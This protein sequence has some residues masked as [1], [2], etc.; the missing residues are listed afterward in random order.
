MGPADLENTLA[1][2]GLATYARFI[3]LSETGIGLLLLTRRF[4]TLGALFLA[5]M[6][7]NILVLTASLHWR[8]TPYM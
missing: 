7:I 5:P 2:Y 1:P 8:G 3:A 4:A 6:L